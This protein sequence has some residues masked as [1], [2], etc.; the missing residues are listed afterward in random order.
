MICKELKCVFVHV[1]KT[2]GQSIERVF[3]DHLGIEWEKRGV[4]LLRKNEDP[5]L[6]PPRL[7]HLTA[8]EYVAHGYLTEPEFEGMYKFAFVRNPWAR[9]VSEYH[10]RTFD[11]PTDFR[12]FVLERFPVPGDDDY[13]HGDDHYRHIMP[14]SRFIYDANGTCLVDYIGRFERLQSDF[15]AACSELGMEPVSLP[16]VNSRRT[17]PFRKRRRFREYFRFGSRKSEKR[18]S[19]PSAYAEMYDQETKALVGNYYAEDIENFGYVF[20]K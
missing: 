4:A 18:H 9:L 6:G 1:P 14:Q 13:E 11:K 2:A 7:A 15:D 8:A 16:H 20:G 3:L 10:Y 17:V 5:D 12:A 19:G